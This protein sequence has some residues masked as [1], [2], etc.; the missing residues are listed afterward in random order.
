MRPPAEGV[1]GA[2]PA[3]F[4][5]VNGAQREDGNGAG[6]IL[7]GHFSVFGTWAEID[8]SFEGHFIER[9]QR[10]AFSKTIAENRSNMRVLFQHGKDPQIGDKPLGPI[11]TLREDEHGA[12]YEVP[13]LATSYNA[14]LIPGLENGL[15]GSSFRFRVVK[16][17]FDPNPRRS[18]YNPERLPERTIKEAR[19]SEFGPVSWP[20]YENATAGLRSL[21]DEVLLGRRP[22]G[23]RRFSLSSTAPNG[24][25]KQTTSRPGYSNSKELDMP[26][27]KKRPF[28]ADALVTATMTFATQD[29]EVH[30]G[31]TFR[32]DDVL[33]VG[34][35]SWFALSD[36]PSGDMPTMWSTL[37]EPPRHRPEPPAPDTRPMVRAVADLY[38]DAGFSG[39]GKPGPSGFGTAVRRG[40]L[41]PL[42]AAIVKAA[43]QNFEHPP[44]PVTP[45][46]FEAAN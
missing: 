26:K 35:P 9:V 25:S 7:A 24:C 38:L 6:S 14:D 27:V 15:Y 4:R 44:R 2:Y 37:P 1:R 28:P 18:S 39:E 16:E 29:R 13:L 30:I 8:S 12:Y 3:K 33:V 20:A 21:S 41:V 10:G 32:S 45:D 40:Q 31:D 23:G 34:N 11:Q 5:L 17:H 43:P 42:D 46:D 19:V 22:R 36:T